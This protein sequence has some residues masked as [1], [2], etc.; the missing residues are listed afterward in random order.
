MFPKQWGFNSVVER[1]ET[2]RGRHVH[3][4]KTRDLSGPLTRS[5]RRRRKRW[6]HGEVIKAPAPPLSRHLPLISL[7]GISPFDRPLRL[8]KQ[9]LK[10]RRQHWSCKINNGVSRQKTSPAIAVIL[11]VGIHTFKEAMH[12][13]SCRNYI[14][15]T[16]RVRSLTFKLNGE[17]LLW[18]GAVMLVS[19]AAGSAGGRRVTVEFF[20]KLPSIII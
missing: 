5:W 19:V 7:S 13:F 8:P 10:Q 17:T 2:V 20:R 9:R 1:H 14:I 4:W 18:K 12:C 11:H 16:V 15:Y 3:F 6:S